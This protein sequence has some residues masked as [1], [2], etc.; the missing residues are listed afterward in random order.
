[1]C[2]VLRAFPPHMV[3]VNCQLLK[4]NNRS[5]HFCVRVSGLEKLRKEDL[6]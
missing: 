4:I 1:M 2:V 5:E 3:T 6:T